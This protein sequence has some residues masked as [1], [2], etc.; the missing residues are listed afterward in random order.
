M[1]FEMGNKAKDNDTIGGPVNV[2]RADS[3]IRHEQ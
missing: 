1:T 2:N 3:D